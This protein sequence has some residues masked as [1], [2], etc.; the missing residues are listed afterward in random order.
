MTTIEL[1]Y[2]HDG[3]AVDLP[4]G[5][6]V[7]EPRRLEGLDDEAGALR[8]ALRAP[9]A[10]PPLHELVPRGATV[11]VVVCDVTR[12]FPA[13]RVLPVL[14]D[15]LDPLGPAHVTVFVA[16]G[17][18]RACTD[19]ELERML[20][21]EVRARCRVVQHDAFDRARHAQLGTVPG[22]DVPALVERE[23]LDHDVRIT[24][25]FIEPHFFAG[26]SGGPKMVTPGLAALE[27]VLE[28]HSAARIGDPAATW[29]VT[30]GNPVHDPVRALAARAAVSFNLDVTLNRAHAITSVFAGELGASH[31]A[32]CAF[33]RD[34]AMAPVARR[35][36]VVVTTNSGWPLD[37]NLYQ[38]VKGLSAAA[39]IV[40]PG[41]TIVLAS[42]CSDGLPEH[43]GYRDLLRRADGPEAFLTALARAD[44]TV[45][46]QWQVQVQAQI[47]RKA[48]VLVKAAGVSHEQL[49]DAWFE[50]VDDVAACVRSELR[51]AGPGARL[52]VVPQG[53]QTIPYVRSRA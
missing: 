39:Q 1:A 45:H 24:T 42:E 3:L 27:T 36:E 34:T 32:G 53:P 26:F 2:G 41:G 49:R 22:T 50:P 17:T 8:R 5:A 37:Q 14:L 19:A 12:P 10:G 44:A 4:A 16:T 25:G 30:E 47:Q 31:A 13:A 38:S 15:E 46:D 48:R 6:D 51:A 11:A 21:P 18:H 23:F 52:A 43:G 28:L 40:R 7:I 20:G 33:A 29:G 9:L 35:Y